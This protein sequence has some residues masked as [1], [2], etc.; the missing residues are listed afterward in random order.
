MVRCTGSVHQVWN[1]V[2]AARRYIGTYEH[3][4]VARGSS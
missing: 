3:N 2:A 4:I 1:I